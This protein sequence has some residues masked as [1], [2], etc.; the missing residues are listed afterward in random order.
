MIKNFKKNKLNKIVNHE[1]NL[2]KKLKEK[3]KSIGYVGY[4]FQEC[5]IFKKN[6]IIVI[7]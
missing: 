2:F 5:K 1:D 4:Y 6:L 7:I 3:E